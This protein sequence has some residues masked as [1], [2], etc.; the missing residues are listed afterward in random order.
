MNV[1]SSKQTEPRIV[2]LE[3][4]FT[5]AEVAEMWGCSVVTVQRLFRNEPGVM[6][7]QGKRGKHA[8]PHLTMRIPRS[9][10]E[11]VHRRNEVA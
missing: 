7:F 2:A 11:R 1:P 3:P 5:P 9:V 6:A 10:L 4:H 8:R